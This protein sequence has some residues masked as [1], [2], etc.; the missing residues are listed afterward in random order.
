MHPLPAD[1]NIEVG[2]AVIDG[3]HSVVYG[4]AEIPL[5]AHKAVMP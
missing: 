4:E 5:H 1:R 3:P 2:D